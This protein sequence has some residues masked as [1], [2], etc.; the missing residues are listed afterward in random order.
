MNLKNI[1]PH[2]LAIA[3]FFVITLIL[4]HPGIIEGKTLNQHDILQWRGGAQE[5][6]Q[7]REQNGEEAYWTNS[8]FSGM[9]AFLV[10]TQYSGDLFVHLQKGISLGIPRPYSL[11]FL[12]FVSFYIMMLTFKVKPL[13]AIA[14]AIAFGATSFM[15]IGLMA[16]HNSRVVAIAFIPLVVAGVKL[17]FDKNIGLGFLLTAI[18]LA[19]EIRVN[20]LQ[21]TYYLAIILLIFG[22]NHLIQSIKAKDFH[23]FKIQMPVLLLA[24]FLAVGAN[25][26]KLSNI[27]SY[28]TYS[29]RGQSELT[30]SKKESGLDKDYAFEFSNGIFEPLVLFIPNFYGGASN[31]KLGK[32]SKL[33]D[34]L[35]KNGVSRVQLDQYTQSVPTYWGK[36]RLSAPYYV[37]SIIIFF[38]VLGILILD[39]RTKMW[40]I[41]LVTLGIVLSWGDNFETFNYFLF[42]YFPGYNKFRSV[43]FTLT[44]AIFGLSTMAVLSLQKVLEID[45]GI[46]RKKLLIAALITA[47][48]A[49]IAALFSGMGAYRAPV[50]QQLA[51]QAPDW[52]IQAIRDDRAR[53]LKIDAIRSAL[54]ITLTV[55]VVWLILK[56]KI[57]TSVGLAAIIA[58]I[59]IDLLTVDKR[60]LKA[61]NFE[62]DVAEA[63]FE[64]SN[65]DA[66]ILDATN[67]GDR[68]LNLQNPFNES[69]TSYLHSSVGGYHGAKLGRYQDL[70]EHH[71][72]PEMNQLITGLQA[73]G[74][75][76]FEKLNVLNM[77]NTRF[78]KYGEAKEN[79]LINSAS[80]GASWYVDALESVQN[81]TEEITKLKEIDT[82]KVAVIDASQ[83]SI[84][85]SIDPDSSATIDLV[86]KTAKKLVYS[87][88]RKNDGLAVFSEIY[89]PE[90]WNASI[91]GEEVEIM[92]VNYVL[93]ALKIPMGESEIIFEFKP[94][95]VDTANTIMLVSGLAIFLLGGGFMFISSRQK[96]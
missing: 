37:G 40:L 47:G 95:G 35:L 45:K 43:T 19:L 78:F 64:K 71:L 6:T 70:I 2:L 16:G 7:F 51:Q 79:V 29:T 27:L 26:G 34:A 88:S 96:Q 5:A 58:L 54:F 84:S 10:S 59:S 28:S 23:V 67:P 76:D 50:D 41:S 92:R 44:L 48:F 18:G 60:Y 30:A 85:F 17:V 15:I 72:T 83:F 1:L 46:A 24:A 21:M 63:Y 52:F 9:P 91:N 66:A 82:K 61:S 73:T 94:V 22:I 55:G 80:N 38:F 4:F 36:Q 86:S 8:M 62:K 14:G 89:Y 53:L 25:Y 93:R 77:L 3:F 31:Q 33:V 90:G 69:K 65:A 12:A 49:L 68:V 11:I 20:H 32:N 87:A 75:P 56:E 42:D 13:I 39:M 57:Q 81:P 74:N